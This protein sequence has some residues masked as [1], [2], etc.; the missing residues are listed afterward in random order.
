M[1]GFDV[2][3]EGIDMDPDQVQAIL[4][5]YKKVKKYQRSNIFEVKTMDGTEDYVSEL[6]KEGEEYGPLD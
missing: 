1:K 2:N 5:K 3:F 4:K 6:I